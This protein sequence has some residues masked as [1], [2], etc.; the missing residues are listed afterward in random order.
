MH[1]HWPILAAALFI[2]VAISLGLWQQEKKAAV[3][4]QKITIVQ[5]SPAATPPSSHPP[6]EKVLPA[7]KPA[8]PHAP[9]P[10][11]T[12]TPAATEATL[13]AGA[14]ALPQGRDDPAHVCLLLRKALEPSMGT[15][16]QDLKEGRGY[17]ITVDGAVVEVTTAPSWLINVYNINT[18]QPQ[19]ETGAFKKC[20]ATVVAQLAIDFSAKPT[21][22]ENGKSNLI[23]RSRLGGV[24]L[25]R[26]PDNGNSCLIR[27][28]VGVPHPAPTVPPAPAVP[29]APAA[30]P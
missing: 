23:T 4:A 8:A 6:A 21:V 5:A 16:A 9:L 2:A 13:P 26:D 1:G 30:K 14:P 25:L 15:A 10:L 17:T 18:R 28:L 19:E 7:E 3:A 11:P 20:Y 22:L 24:L 29:T 12:A 27:P